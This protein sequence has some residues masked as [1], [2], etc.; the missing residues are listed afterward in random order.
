MAARSQ[1]EI[2]SAACLVD[3]N[4]EAFVFFFVDQIIVLGISPQLMTIKPV[5]TLGGVFYGVEKGL[6]V[7]GPG[8]GTNLLHRVCQVFAGAQVAHVQP[9]LTKA[10]IVSGISQQVAVITNVIS[11]KSHEFLAPGQLVDVQ[12]N[13]LGSLQVAF[14]PGVDWILL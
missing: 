14:F 3:K 5:L 11:T 9:I 1:E 6:V 4:I 13:L 2:F 12:R 8:D 10:S 7:I